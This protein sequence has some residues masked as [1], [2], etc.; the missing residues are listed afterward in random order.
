MK[1]L[2]HAGAYHHWVESSFPNEIA[3]NKRSRKLWR[4][5]VLNGQ[6]YLLIVSEIEPDLTKLEENGI[7]GSGEVK[8]YNSFIQ[9]LKK[10][11]AYRFRVTLNPVV[12]R[13]VEGH[14]RGVVMPHVT[15]EQQRQF[16]LERA[17]KNG[18]SLKEDGFTIVE[19]GYLNYKKTGQKPIRLS[20][21]TYEGVLEI[22]DLEVFKKT[23]TE[24]FGKKKAYGFGMM[25]VIPAM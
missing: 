23:L 9:T 15:V 4:I 16:L 11:E 25:T 12:A 21:V 2:S 24:G 1:E 5:D 18:F 8:N 17:E 22:S 10:G 3:Q 13:K 7:R 19:R 6:H 20:K 14:E